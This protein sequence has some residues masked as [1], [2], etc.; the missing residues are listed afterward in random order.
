MRHCRIG[1]FLF[2][3]MRNIELVINNGRENSVAQVKSD[4]SGSI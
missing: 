1:P 4:Y 3:P 2:L